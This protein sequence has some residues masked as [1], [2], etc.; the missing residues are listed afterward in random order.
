MSLIYIKDVP[1]SSKIR[2]RRLSPVGM[3]REA[4]WGWGLLIDI[5]MDG[6][7]YLL[8][9]NSVEMKAFPCAQG[10][11]SARSGEICWFHR[12]CD[13]RFQSHKSIM[14]KKDSRI[15]HYLWRKPGVWR[16]LVT[17]IRSLALPRQEQSILWQS[18]FK[19]HHIGKK[20]SAWSVQKL[21]GRYANCSDGPTEKHYIPVSSFGW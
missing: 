9:T 11:S 19:Y 15:I 1:Q 20:I 12:E 14:P 18:V 6:R 21:Y 5:W 4:P 2:Y 10:S 7:I 8:S 17:Y 3:N 16:S 13:C